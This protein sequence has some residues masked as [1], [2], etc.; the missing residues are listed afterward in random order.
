MSYCEDAL[1]DYL[2]VLYAA[3]IGAP[4]SA[5]L[6]RWSL[7][8]RYWHDP[9]WGAGITGFRWSTDAKTLVV[10]TSPIYGSGGAFRLDLYRRTVSQLLPKGR[11]VT[12]SAPGPG[13]T[14]NQIRTLLK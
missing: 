13:Y 7:A 3:P 10:V 12:V 1:G 2:A 6:G 9:L 14:L 5:G 11:K 8:D 4:T